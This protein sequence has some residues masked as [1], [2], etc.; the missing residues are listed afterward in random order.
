MI[1]HARSCISYMRFIPTGTEYQPDWRI[2]ITGHNGVTKIVQIE[3]H[4]TCIPVPE[5]SHLK[6]YKD[7]AFQYSM[8]KHQIDPVMLIVDCDS[9]L[10]CFKTE[11][12]AKFKKEFL[13]IIEQSCLKIVFTKLL[14]F[15]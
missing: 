6:I 2:I 11:S 9:F 3:I 12:V 4:L 13:D 5:F 1:I 10:P 8:V 14:L 7:M 15:G